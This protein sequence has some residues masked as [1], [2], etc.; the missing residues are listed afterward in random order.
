V[1][2]TG[3][4]RSY[5]YGGYCCYYGYYPPY[6]YHPAYYG[7]AYNP[8][9][10]P[11]AYGWGWGGAPWFG[12]YGGYFSPYATYPSASF[13]LTDYIISQD[14]QAAYAAHQEAVAVAGDPAAGG[15]PALSP[16]VKQQIADEVKAQLALENQEAGQTAQNQDVDP[17]S[18]GIARM[19]GDGHAHVFVVG[20][21]LDL[22]DDS[23]QECAVSEGDALALKT[24]PPADATTANLVV[25]ASKGGQECHSGG[26][27]AVNLTDLQEMQNHLRE[28]IDVGLKELQDKQGKGGLPA[29]PASAQAAPTQSP[30]AAVAP[31]PDP[32]DA[33]DIQQQAQQAD[34]AEKEVTAAVS[35][36][37]GAPIAAADSSA[38][39]ATV[40]LGQTP[41]QVVSALGQPVRKAD[42]PGKLIYFYSGM[43]VTFKGGKVTDV[44]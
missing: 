25:L 24:P 22:T 7:W 44:E 41:D 23:G 4:Y 42:L 21:G 27:V 26:T 16:E 1:T 20:G 2:Y 3:V 8:W 31:P 38:P 11:V 32:K 6:Y 9:P 39:P 15:P 40:A 13:W 12:F 36:D 19:L 18:S 29:A 34:Q 33:A 14:L 30:Y 17:G 10:A 35:A 5:G 43:K 28:T 37:S